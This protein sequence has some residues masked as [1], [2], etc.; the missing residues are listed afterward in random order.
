MPFITNAEGN[1]FVQS[2]RSERFVWL[3]CTGVGD[4]ELPA[5]AELTPVYCPDP[6]NSGDFK[7]DGFIKGDV[8][9][10]TY[11]LEKP[12]ATVYN[13]LL[14]EPCPFGGRINWVCRGIRQDERNYEIAVVMPDST[15]GRRSIRN[16]VRSPGGTEERVMTNL[17]L[18]FPDALMIYHLQIVRQVLTNTVPANAI[19]F[20]PQRCED[21]C[22]AA[23]GLCETG[24]MGLD[25]SGYLGYVLYPYDS[26]IKKTFNGGA[27]WAPTATDP[28]TYGGNTSAILMMETSGGGIRI[29][30]FR[31]Q[32]VPGAPAESAYSDDL[33]VTWN[34]SLV[35]GVNGQAVT[36]WA[37]CGAKI[38]VSCTGGYIYESSDQAESWQVQEAGVETGED[39]NDIT[40]YSDQIG[41]CVG[42]NNVFLYTL[43]AGADWA[44]GNRPAVPGVNLLSCAVNDKGHLFCG[45]NDAR[46][47]RTEDGGADLWA[48]VL[49]L[50]GGTIPW[51]RFDPKALYVGAMIHNNTTPVGS[52]Y[53]SE[54]GGA[55]WPII[56]NMPAN[57]GLNGGF[58][59]DQ[60]HIFVVGELHADGTTFVAYTQPV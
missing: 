36:S 12:L 25:G 26:E 38:V 14:E 17:D 1:Y 23:R 48:E 40:F 58:V 5:T 33:G 53:R 13:F 16:P 35:G 4:L 46:L 32:S 9:M 37:L 60:N 57:N 15:P 3:T 6:L 59:C 29:I 10:G 7:I 42:D 18:S 39:L 49:D 43:N 20:L 51:I 45:S 52:L 44:M 22:G 11:S 8:G 41:Y 27:A 54:D 31:S 55:S 56:A 50:G 24:V 34:N 19:Y 21:R 28:Y 2:Q 30:A 47:F